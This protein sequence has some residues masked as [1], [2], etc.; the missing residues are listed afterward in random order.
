MKSRLSTPQETATQL[1]GRWEV[2]FSYFF[3]LPCT[4][5]WTLALLSLLSSF[6][7][8][9]PKMAMFDTA[10]VALVATGLIYGPFWRIIKRSPAI[11][12]GYASGAV[13][14]CVAWWMA[15]AG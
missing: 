2:V 8:I 6:N 10:A 1:T 12:A 4:A 7:L 15:N 3:A 9:A 5:L 11:L 13:F 14:V